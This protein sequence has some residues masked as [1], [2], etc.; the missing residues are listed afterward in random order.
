MFPNRSCDSFRFAFTMPS[1]KPQKSQKSRELQ[2]AARMAE[3][4]VKRVDRG[5]LLTRVAWGSMPPELTDLDYAFLDY[6]LDDLVSKANAAVARACSLRG[7]TEAV[8]K[9]PNA[10][11]DV[12]RV[13]ERFLPGANNVCVLCDVRVVDGYCLLESDVLLDE[14]EEP[15]TFTDGFLV[16]FQVSFSLPK[17]DASPVR[18]KMTLDAMAGI[19][20]NEGTDAI[21]GYRHAYAR[22]REDLVQADVASPGAV[23]K[24]YDE[25]LAAFDVPVLAR[26]ALSI[27]FKHEVELNMGDTIV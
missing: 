10:E 26:D 4:M 14:D 19:L 18:H 24:I 9:P 27:S 5:R 25:L 22:A 6:D 17:T 21:L 1:K 3:R 11:Q 8:R 13:L 12:Q 15:V 23:R 20:R 2:L 16:R 7:G